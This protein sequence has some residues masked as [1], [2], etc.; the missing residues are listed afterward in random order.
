MI[1]MVVE[2]F[3]DL[4]LYFFLL[5]MIEMIMVYLIEIGDSVLLFF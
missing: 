3:V 2:G 5:W 4:I 1:G